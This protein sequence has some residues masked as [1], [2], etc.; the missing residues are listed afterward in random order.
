M[1]PWLAHCSP[2]E[3]LSNL[4]QTP[5]ASSFTHSLGA[6]PKPSWNKG[7]FHNS[8]GPGRPPIAAKHHGEPTP[9]PAS[10]PGA[11][12]SEARAPTASLLQPR[13]ALEVH[14]TFHPT[15]GSQGE[16]GPTPATQD[17]HR[18]GPC[19]L[20]HPVPTYHQGPAPF[21]APSLF[22]CGRRG[23]LRSPLWPSS[24]EY[25][26]G[27]TH[28]KYSQTAVLSAWQ[29]PTCPHLVPHLVQG[30]PQALRP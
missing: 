3:P 5:I 21:L 13:L 30:R 27:V 19:P 1:R 11:V 9:R 25:P 6:L 18:P 10:L 23:G 2:Q 22:P 15:V 20:V 24:L 7:H 12:G 29:L 8:E 26:H 28:P 14:W 17:T 16:P 4:H